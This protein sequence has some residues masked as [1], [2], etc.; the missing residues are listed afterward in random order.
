MKLDY[1]ATDF[2]KNTHIKFNENPPFR[3]RVPC[4]QTGGP[5]DIKL[6]VAVRNF[7]NAPESDAHFCE[8]KHLIM[9]PWPCGQNLAGKCEGKLLCG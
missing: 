2:S 5:T 9:V 1:F 6:I 3:N 4:G 7:A 8:S